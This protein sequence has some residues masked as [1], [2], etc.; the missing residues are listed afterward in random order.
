[1]TRAAVSRKTRGV[2]PAITILDGPVGTELDRRGV[3]TELPRW[4]AA[5]I[6][7]APGILA[8]IHRDYARAGATVHTACTFRTQPGIL[9]ADFERVARDA[10]RIARGAVPTEH[11]VAGSIAPIADCYRPDLSPGEAS[12]AG[13]RRLARVLADEGVDLLLVETFP[14]ETEALVALEEA[15]ATGLPSWLALTAGPSGSLLSPE[16]VHRIAER[17]RSLGASAIL[18][19]CIPARVIGGF[20]AAL[21]DVG[22]PFGAYANA[23]SVDDVVGWRAS[24]E[25]GASLYADLA[26]DWIAD[27]A[28]IV[29]GCCGT[30]VPHVAE[31]ARRFGA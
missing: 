26:A 30:G 18:V 24:V 23:G 1:M 11:R 21:R 13:H 3:R 12:R 10:V 7:E 2:D 9:G 15:L 25:P 28:T 8:A 27:G 20:V 22:L 4:S 6:D 29:G 19:N 17:A 16:S 14:A 5:A 31:L